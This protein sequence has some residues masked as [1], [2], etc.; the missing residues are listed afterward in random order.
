MDA[1]APGFD[2]VGHEDEHTGRAD[3]LRDG[4]AG[5]GA[6]HL[7]I[8]RGRVGTETR[9][10]SQVLLP[11]CALHDPGHLVFPPFQMSQHVYSRWLCPRSEDSSDTGTLQWLRGLERAF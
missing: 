2:V 6:T 11:L 10:A 8:W 5:A 7:L 1:A 4:H 9:K 3:G